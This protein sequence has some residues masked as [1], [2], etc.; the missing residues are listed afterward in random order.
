MAA[1]WSTHGSTLSA[2]IESPRVRETVRAQISLAIR[3]TYDELYH[4]LHDKKNGYVNPG[5]IAVH[6]PEE[7]RLVL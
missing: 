5:S 6:T 3:Q 7:L 1:V 2:K 4:L